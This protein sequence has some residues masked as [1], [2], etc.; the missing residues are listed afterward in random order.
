MA[1]RENRYSAQACLGACLLFGITS[2]IL[3][4]AIYGPLLWQGNA[5]IK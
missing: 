4:K 3:I 2:A 5:N 1:V